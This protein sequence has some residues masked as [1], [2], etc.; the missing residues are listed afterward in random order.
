M[1]FI[2]CDDLN[3]YVLHRNGSPSAKTPHIDRLAE[4]GVTFVNMHAVTPVCGPSRTCL[5]TGIY[6]Q[7]H[8]NFNVWKWDSI[9]LLKNSVPIPQ[10]FLKNG[11]DVYG[12][13]KLFHEGAGGNFWTAYGI[14]PNY[15]PWPWKG[16]GREENTA[17]PA[18]VPLFTPNLP[19]N[20]Q[21]DLNYG[22]LSQVP[23]WKP[24]PSKN[25]PGYSGWHS[26]GK[27]FRYVNDEDRNPMPDEISAKFAI[28][29]LEAEDDKPFFLA[30]GF[31]RPHTP[32]Y[33]PRST[34]TCSPSKVFSCPPI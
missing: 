7:W 16:K 1:L 8:G 34:S 10:H 11:Y 5:W 31:I 17:H 18:Q 14:P 24:N 3:H 12:T 21:R 25:I 9:P 32:L 13:G 27:P 4:Q 33:A 22:P 15:G 26:N 20:I 30:V 2:I 19:E 6:P 23:Q 29:R 28:E